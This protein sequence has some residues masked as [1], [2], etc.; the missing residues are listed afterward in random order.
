MLWDLG[1]NTEGYSKAALQAAGFAVGFDF[2]Q[3]AL[4]LACARARQEDLNF[5]PLFLDATNSAPGGGWAQSERRGLEARAGVDAI[6]ALA[7]VH[8]L[9][10]AKNIP[11]DR[12]VARLIRMAPADVI[13]FVPKNDAMVQELLRLREDIFPRLL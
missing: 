4:E 3:G 9:A 8:H 10:I 1:C 5:L 11:L 13:E 12:V 6:L 2:D 7:L